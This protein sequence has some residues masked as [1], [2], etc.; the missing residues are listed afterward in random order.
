MS[1]AA[2]RIADRPA[3]EKLTR[4]VTA[5]D[6]FTFSHDELRATQIEAMNERFQE[7]KDTH[8][9]ARPSRRGSGHHRGPQPRG[10][11]AAAVP[12]HRLQELSRK[13][14]DASRSGTGWASGST[15]ISTH[16]I[17]PIDTADIADIDDWIERLQA[18]RPLRLL[19]ERHDRQVGDAD[20][21]AEGHGLVASS[22]RSASSP[23]D[24]A[25]SRRATAGCSAWRPSP[26]CRKNNVIGEAQT[27]AFGDP[28]LRALRLSGA[29]DHR[30]RA[31]PDGGAAQ[32]DRR[33]HRAARRHR[34][35]RADL[36]E[37]QKAV[38]DAVGITAE[39][40]IAAAADKLYVSGLWT[41]STRSPRRCA[42]WATAPRTSIRTTASM[43]A[44][45]SSARSCRDDYQRVRLR[46]VQH[47]A[48]AALPELQHAGAAIPACRAAAK[49]GRYHVPPWVVP[50]I[51]NKD[52]DAL[53]PHRP[54][55]SIEGPRGLLR[56][57]ARRPLGRRHLRRQDLDRLQP[58]RLRQQGPVDP[59]QY[60]PLRRS[61]RRRQ[62]RLRGH[63]RCLRERCGMNSL[64][65]TR[66]AARRRRSRRSPRPS[67]SAASWSRA[68]MPSTARATSASTFATPRDRSRSRWS[69]RAPSCRRCS[70]CRSRRSSTSWS[71]PASG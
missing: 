24:R 26:M 2:E 7:R 57:V 43:S 15:P 66:T 5:D 23:G 6:R 39:A 63:R 27:A 25:C 46:D 11:G 58:V 44:A 13:L 53:L 37:R 4:L 22:T 65:R 8:Q 50:L 41:G 47:P 71:R 18:K 45:G 32:G 19:L 42:T 52:G 56:P 30:R 70:T 21:V 69:I 55:A 40:L 12:A 3:V 60:R 16:P 59:R 31:D 1:T 51:L 35:V 17:A 49:G 9:A 48:R 36:G 38:D 54:T 29:A 67:S 20:R 64:I 62:D 34:R 33:R 14:P 10:R 68:A 61:R 28:R